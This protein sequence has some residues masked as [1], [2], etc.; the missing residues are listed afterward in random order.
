MPLRIREATAADDGATIEILRLGDLSTR[1]PDAIAFYRS[2]PNS[3]AFVGSVE[4]EAVA[5]GLGVH[6]GEAGWVGNIA[7][8]P[9]HRRRGY[10]TAMTEHVAGWLRDRGARTVLLTAT[11]EGSTVYERAGFVEDGGVVYGAWMRPEPAREQHAAPDI[12]AVTPGALAHAIDLDRLATGEDRSAYLEPFFGRIRATEGGYRIGMPWGTGPIIAT[13][14]GAGRALLLD[15]LMNDPN[16]R[17]GFPDSNRDAVQA[18]T[19]A[20]FE[21]VA[22]DIRMRL[23]PPVEGFRPQMIWCVLSFVCG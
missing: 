19:D 22:E 16:P 1:Q 14:P 12:T 4:G 3:R 11:A 23:G 9:S 17:V 10:G 18:A 7:V 13:S 21:R 2:R 8:H 20:G 5:A 6:F 15:L